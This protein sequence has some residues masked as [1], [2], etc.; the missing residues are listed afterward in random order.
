M[1]RNNRADENEVNQLKEDLSKAKRRIA[2]L[3]ETA[4]LFKDQQNTSVQAAAALQGE[5]RSFQHRL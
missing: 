5:V 1:L 2:E 4:E 3:Q